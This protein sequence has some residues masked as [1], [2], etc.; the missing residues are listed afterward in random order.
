LYAFFEDGRRREDSDV[1]PVRRVQPE[2]QMVAKS[3]HHHR[4]CKP[5]RKRWAKKNDDDL[6]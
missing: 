1:F 4:N 5:R 3:S 2:G 6:L